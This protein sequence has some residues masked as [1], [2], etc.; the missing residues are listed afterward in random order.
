MMQNY[1]Q[2]IVPR[3]DGENIK[4]NFRRYLSLVRKGIA[5]FIVFGGELEE[6]RR[7]I[8]RL[9]ADSRIPLIVASD[10]ERGLGQQLRGGTLFPPAMALAHSCGNAK[11][12]GTDLRLL[13]R[14]FAAVADEA[15]Y[16]GI[17]TILAPVLDVNTNPKN[18]IIATRSFGED[19]QTVSFFACEMIRT[20]QRHGI[21][22]CGK[23][24]PGHGDTEI[25]SHI[26]LPSITRGLRGLERKEFRPFQDAMDAGVKM[27][28]LGHL[29]VPAL[30]P[31]GIPVSLSEKA[32]AYLRKKMKYEGILITD[33][34]N[35]GGIGKYREERASLMALRAGADI[36]LHPSDPEAV[37]RRLEREGV[38]L[39]CGRLGRFR[40]GLLSVTGALRPDF[41]KHKT[42]SAILAKRAINTTGDFRL[43][44]RT[45]LVLVNDEDEEKGKTFAVRMRKLI[46]GLRTAAV[47]RNSG[48]RTMKVPDNVSVI[49]AVFS[50]TKAWKGGASEWLYRQLQYFDGKAGLFISF[51]SPYLLDSMSGAKI[52]AYWDSDEAQEAV[53]DLIVRGARKVAKAG[54]IDFSGVPPRIVPQILQATDR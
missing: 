12:G 29:N 28:M 17:N 27:I 44:G 41:E 18:P 21:A 31:S 15:R 26:G 37:A 22:A 1:Y 36:I 49:V 39:D 4:D 16:A 20:L 50:D 6:V 7:Y 34:M 3:L 8:K 46:P 52:Y 32:V 35:M 40:K 13:R 30:D 23:H 42:L 48:S 10:L 43:R 2:F 5:G 33:A 25:D 14:S 47:R 19:A 11:T 51:G 45:L 9:Q 54:G 24:F 38:I 53:A